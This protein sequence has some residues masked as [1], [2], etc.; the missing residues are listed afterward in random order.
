LATRELNWDSIVEVA[1]ETGPGVIS[2]VAVSVMAEPAK[3]PLIV[4][5]PAV[6]TEVSVAL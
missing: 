3:V 1:K 5:V 4:A 2:T 6:M